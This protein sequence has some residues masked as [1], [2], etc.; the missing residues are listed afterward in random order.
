MSYTALYRKWRSRDFEEIKGQ[1][2]IIQS[3][4][5]QVMT[6]RVGH[7]Y[8]FCGTRGTGKTSVA[9]ILSRAVNCESP[10]NGNPCNQCPSCL[11]ILRESSMDVVE[12]D[13]ASNNGV[14]DIRQI[15][16]Q[17]QYPPVSGK[18]KVYIID[19]V[20][21]LSQA[22]FNAF[23]K[24]LEEPPEYVI[25][26]LATTEPNKIPITILS[27]C[28]RY[29]FKRITTETITAR[30]K[31]IAAEEHIDISDEA[32][33]F[34]ARAGDGSMR[35]SVSLLDQCA[36]FQFDRKISYDDALKILG[37]VDTAVFSEIMH[38]IGERDAASLI[39]VVSE[40]VSQGRELAQF[41]TDLIQ[42]VRN[43][44]LVKMMS[45]VSGLV[46]LSSD[47]MKRL[48][49]DAD[50]ISVEELM[51]YIRMLSELSN[52]LRYA[53]EK[54][55]LI[56]TVLLKMAFPETDASNE[57]LAAR[58][59]ELKRILD[60]GAALPVRQTDKTSIQ[61]EKKDPVVLSK[62]QFEDLQK[63]KKDW[64]SICASLSDGMLSNCLKDA[65]IYPVNGDTMGIALKSG[66]AYSTFKDTEYIRK[67][68]E[69]VE[70]RYQKAFEFRIE[71]IDKADTEVSY[72]TNEELG[73]I[74]IDIE[75]SK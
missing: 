17:V 34:V 4:K 28:Q 66:A 24:T 6:N 11:S 72:I 52:Q 63:L 5:N 40:V 61:P 27:R 65:Y 44:L 21:M 26:I 32:V 68:K 10:V 56:E 9:K 29:D 41:I 14:E 70:K 37:A 1:E 49:E 45:D 75:V 39:R 60:R 15:R 22:A 23:L 16:E 73:N 54:R 2:P 57:G 36:A 47:N 46:E 19:E 3:L 33:S 51:R 31:E 38:A 53:I 55:I 71:M 7:A 43:M 48:K 67:L 35:D 30:L 64:K 12:M 62:A 18:Y 8:L 58:M 69:C 74:S 20:H 13:A 50:Q 42:Y 59:G 25:F